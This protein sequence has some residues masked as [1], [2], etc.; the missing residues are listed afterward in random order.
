[1]SHAL[2]TAEKRVDAFLVPMDHRSDGV[3]SGGDLS[4]RV[5]V[6]SSRLLLR[7]PHPEKLV[8]ARAHPDFIYHKNFLYVRERA[9]ELSFGHVTF[10]HPSQVA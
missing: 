10:D 9:N 1:M 3:S 2:E 6:D 8:L 4:K 5:S 7:R